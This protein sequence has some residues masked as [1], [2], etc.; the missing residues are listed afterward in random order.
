MPENPFLVRRIKLHYGEKPPSLKETSLSVS[1]GVIL[2]ILLGVS[3][4]FGTWKKK[5]LAKKERTVEIVSGVTHKIDEA[6]SIF[7]LNPVRARELVAE[8][9]SLLLASSESDLDVGLREDITN[10]IKKAEEKILGEYEASP[11]VFLDLSLVNPNFNSVDISAAKEKVFIVDASQ[12][13]VVEVNLVSKRSEVVAGPDQLGGASQVITAS[14]YLFFVSNAGVLDGAGAV[15]INRSWDSDVLGVFYNGNLYLVEG[16]A[17]KIYR[18][19]GVGTGSTKKF[20][21]G[22]MWLKDGAWEGNNKINSF[23]ADG[24]LWVL[25]SQGEILKFSLGN[26]IGFNLKGMNFTDF[27]P[28]KLY[29]SEELTSLYLLDTQNGKVFV[30]S[31]NGD[32]QAQYTSNDIKDALGLVVSETYKRVFLLT[33]SKLIYFDLTHLEN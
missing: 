19:S 2:I 31:K 13:Q 33:P 21:E 26:R 7:S 11:Q 12:K 23:L 10:R 24:F 4:F 15:V 8:A 14:E 5:D 16:G 17:S 3:I 28:S 30:V 18:F 20:A 1:V 32:Y 22:T 6:N 9:K 29:T 27:K 25:T